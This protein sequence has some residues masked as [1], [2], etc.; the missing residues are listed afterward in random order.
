[1]CNHSESIDP[2]EYASIRGGFGRAVDAE[3][4]QAFET[5]RRIDD[6]G[7]AFRK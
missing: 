3:G 6:D 7:S 1:V 4:C 5:D 2:I